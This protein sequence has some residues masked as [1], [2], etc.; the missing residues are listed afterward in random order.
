MHRGVAVDD[1]AAR[2]RV[3]A[4]GAERVEGHQ[5]EVAGPGSFRRHARRQRQVHLARAGGEA[6]G[7][8]AAGAAGAG[9]RRRR[10]AA[11]GGGGGGGGR[12]AGGGR[13]RA[14]AP[15][16]VAT[17]FRGPELSFNASAG[18][19][20][21]VPARAK[22]VTCVW[23]D[24]RPSRALPPAAAPAPSPAPAPDLP[25]PPA[26]PSPRAPAAAPSPRRPDPPPFPAAFDADTL[27][28]TT[29][30][31]RPRPRGSPA[32]KPKRCNSVPGAGTQTQRFSQRRRECAGAC[33]ECTAPV[34]R[35]LPNAAAAPPGPPPAPAGG[36]PGRRRAPAAS[37]AP[38][39][40]PSAGPAPY[41]RKNAIRPKMKA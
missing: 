14:A 29:A 38:R 22:S 21:S 37:A 36:G 40:R 25:R 12:A 7:R 17:Q 5:P 27:H 24:C 16:S 9:G 8:A 6:G 13:R 35:L 3:S 4:R 10:A 11:A 20:E 15:R 19:G 26:G 33:P 39:P 28:T 18:A 31:R 1:D 2:P 23:R 41:D 32:P 34:T 30:V